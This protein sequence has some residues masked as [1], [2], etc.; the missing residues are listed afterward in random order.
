MLT[1]ESNGTCGG[2]A[3]AGIGNGNGPGGGEFYVIDYPDHAQV[4]MAGVAQVP[5]FP[6]VPFTMY[7]PIFDSTEFFDGGAGWNSAANGGGARRYRI[8]SSNDSDPNTFAKGGGLGDLE[9]LCEAAPIEIGN[10]VWADDT[11]NGVQDPGEPVLPGVGVTLVC[12]SAGIN[13][14]TTTDANG[15]YLFNSSNVSGGVPVGVACEVRINPA[16]ANLGGRVAT[17]AN[18]GS[19]DLHDSD[20]VLSGG[21]I[22]ASFTT[23][24]AGF[25]NHTYDFGFTMLGT[26]SVGDTV[27]CD[28]L[29]GTGNGTFD[30]GE[31]VANV[32]V[33]LFDDSDCDDVAD[34][35]ATATQAT[36]G[37]G[38]YFFT[39]LPIGPPGSP[40]CYVVQVD[41]ADADLGTCDSPIT[42]IEFAPDLDSDTP[43]D[44]TND[45]GFEEPC[46]DPDGDGICNE[47][48]TDDRDD[49]GIPDCD[50]FDPQGYFYCGATGAILPG[51]LVGVTGPGAVNLIEDG[52]SGRYFFFTDGTPGTYSLSV[53][54]PAGTTSSTT[55]TDLGVLDPTGIPDPLVL[56]SG[57]QG[58]HWCSRLDRVHGQSLLPDLRPGGRRP[59]GDQQQP[60]P[61]RMRPAIHGDSDHLGMGIGP[62]GSPAGGCRSALAEALLIAAASGGDAVVLGR[63][64]SVTG[65]FR[66]LLVP[67]VLAL[68]PCSPPV[69]RAGRDPVASGFRIRSHTATRDP[70]WASHQAH[71]VSSRAALE[72]RRQDAADR[73]AGADRIPC[74]SRWRA[75]RFIPREIELWQARRHRL[76]DR[77]LFTQAPDGQW[78][79]RVL[80]P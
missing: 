50:D 1:L 56:G 55:C 2:V 32:T 36:V 46:D 15:Q 26:G 57:E 11:I 41:S 60:S 51:G 52:S 18:S 6:D 28:G 63:G 78:R 42:P 27:W 74:P 77:T 71:P 16:D 14:S 62:I 25:N 23:G 58:K 61:R 80:E 53:T 3:G 4:T 30:A 45:F 22:A 35:A 13:V 44:L 8:Y 33:S 7:D 37:D 79:T 65:G 64:A 48:C 21:F 19:N 59:E 68:A 76:H 66:P 5:G 49:D 34:G 10:R 72:A 31:G 24:A 43:D 39:G 17:L 9:A 40:V 12:A 69:R 67:S 38:Q 70:C 54:P 73:F 47:S 29:A 75:Y 20:G